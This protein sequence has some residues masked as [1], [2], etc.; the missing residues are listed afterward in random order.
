MNRYF[1]SGACVAAIVLFSCTTEPCACPPALTQLVAV[2]TVSRPD[3]T[4]VAG[5]SVDF[6]AQLGTSC[7][8]PAVPV[9]GLGSATTDAAGAFMADLYSSSAGENCLIV[10][11]VAGSDTAKFWRLADF[12]VGGDFPDTL[13][14]AFTLGED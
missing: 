14:L 7:A 8:P 1:A 5:A 10:T 13:R 9:E 6:A 12:G 2:G 11:V 3:Q 4:P